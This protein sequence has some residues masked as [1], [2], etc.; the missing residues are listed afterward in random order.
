MSRHNVLEAQ[1]ILKIGKMKE[2]GIVP[3]IRKSLVQLKHEEIIARITKMRNYHK[4]HVPSKAAIGKL[5]KSVFSGPLSVLDAI[6]SD[7]TTPH[8]S[9][10]QS[11]L[12]EFSEV[13]L[14]FHSRIL[15][16]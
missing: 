3:A 4:L 15:K 14:N 8:L 1:R 16:V 5:Q 13:W 9:V 6:K 7:L 2:D 11:F 10:L 12:F